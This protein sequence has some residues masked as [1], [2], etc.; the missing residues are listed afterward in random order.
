MIIQLTDLP[1]LRT[2]LHN[3]TIATASGVFDL[4]HV[5][6]VKYLQSLKEYGD[7]TVVIIKPD[8]R[9]KRHKHPRRPVIP[10][11]DRA[12]MVDAIKGVDYVVIGSYNPDDNAAVDSMYEEFFDLLKPDSYVATNEDWYKLA[13][14]TDATVV[15]LPRV[16]RGEFAS[17]TSIIRHIRELDSV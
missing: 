12:R 3:K 7:S 5:G 11:H 8:A 9:I 16:K 17:T 14:V 13:Q 4:L 10:E 1:Q 2:T 6:H 15:E